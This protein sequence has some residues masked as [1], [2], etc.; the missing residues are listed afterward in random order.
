MK[1]EKE[2]IN[3]KD[4]FLVNYGIY[5]IIIISFIT[6]FSLYLLKIN[7]KSILLLVI[8]YYSNKNQ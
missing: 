1:I 8:E 3:R 6:L 4:Y 5:I 7:D 2:I